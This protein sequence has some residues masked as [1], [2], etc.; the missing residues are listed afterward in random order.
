MIPA[1]GD[2]CGSN[3]NCVSDADTKSSLVFFASED[4]LFVIESRYMGD[5]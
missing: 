3:T 5:I 1:G 4:W 2:V